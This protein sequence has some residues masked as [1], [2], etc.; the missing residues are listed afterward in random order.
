MRWHAAFLC[1]VLGFAACASSKVYLSKNYVRPGRVAVL[2]MSNDTN[3]LDGPIFVRKALFNMLVRH[4]YQLI[5]LDEVDAK[6]KVQGFTDGGQL[7]AATPQKIG[8]W[9]GADGLFYSTLEDFN[10]ILLGFYTQREVKIQGQMVDAQTGEKLWESEGGLTS[11]VVAASKEEAKRQFA[12]QTATK[13]AEKLTHI[14]LQF[15]TEAAVVRLLNTL[16]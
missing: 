14:P 8:E 16:P 7:K 6:L 13:F 9:I 5:P 15:E 2:P 11:R 10:Y 4:G 12:I 3:D 1:V